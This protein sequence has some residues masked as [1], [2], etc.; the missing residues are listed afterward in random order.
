[1]IGPDHN[2]TI[3]DQTLRLRSEFEEKLVLAF[4]DV[5]NEDYDLAFIVRGDHNMYAFDSKCINIPE[6]SITDFGNIRE[7]LSNS[8]L[9]GGSFLDY[10]KLVFHSPPT[11]SFRRR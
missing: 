10:L 11:C 4:A 7:N 9:I 6:C 2:L 8:P 3:M 5:S 1:M